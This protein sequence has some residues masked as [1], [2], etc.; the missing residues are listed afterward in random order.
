MGRRARE[1][2]VNNENGR[3]EVIS[4]RQA[5][6]NSSSFSDQPPHTNALSPHSSEQPPQSEAGRPQVSCKTAYHH[7]LR[8]LTVQI[9][10]QLGIAGYGFRPN[11][12]GFTDTGLVTGPRGRYRLQFNASTASAY[13]TRPANDCAHSPGARPF[14]SPSFCLRTQSDIPENT[15]IHRCCVSP[16][17][18]TYLHVPWSILLLIKYCVFLRRK[19]LRV[20]NHGLQ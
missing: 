14:A 11:S 17:R 2:V 18:G 6:P 8:D 13:T 16:S 19:T 15:I 10:I 12:C 3:G 9:L 20:S 7:F 1:N 4:H 5:Q